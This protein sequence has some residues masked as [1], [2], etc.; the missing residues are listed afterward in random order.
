[1]GQPHGRQPANQ[2]EG[3]AG[4]PRPE[5]KKED[6]M[7]MPPLKQEAV[8]RCVTGRPFF[9]RA[10]GEVDVEAGERVF[11][12]TDY[13]PR[14]RPLALGGAPSSFAGTGIAAFYLSSHH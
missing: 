6:G 4:A 3:E 5:E 2:Q 8:L 1:M 13:C 14:A 10:S 12:D 11:T 7:P 9:P